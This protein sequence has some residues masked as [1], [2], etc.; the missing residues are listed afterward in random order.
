MTR[1]TRTSPPSERALVE[2]GANAA[3][4][5]LGQLLKAPVVVAEVS[6]GPLSTVAARHAPRACA[7]TFTVTGALAGR[8]VL[9]AREDAARDIATALVG[10]A[11]EKRLMGALTELGNITASAFLNGV[12]ALLETSCVPS[13]PDIEIGDAEKALTTAIGHAGEVLFA[14]LTTRSGQTIDLV[15]SR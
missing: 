2:A 1:V 11:N 5:A 12:A 10:S 15:L 6:S 8:F 3:A 4:R 14:R 13:V 7:V 9:L